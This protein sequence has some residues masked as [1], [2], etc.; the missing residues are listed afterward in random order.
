MRFVPVLGV[1]T[2]EDAKDVWQVKDNVAKVKM[3]FFILL[4]IMKQ[5]NASLTSLAED[6]KV[7]RR[8]RHN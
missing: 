7:R 5:T 3:M 2:A 6:I 4:K 1:D 8:L